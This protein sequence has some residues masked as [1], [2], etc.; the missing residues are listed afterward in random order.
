MPL[1]EII[2]EQALES[3]L[4]GQEIKILFNE[5]KVYFAYLNV[6]HTEM[7]KTFGFDGSLKRTVPGYIKPSIKT[8]ELRKSITFPHEKVKKVMQ[9]FCLLEELKLLDGYNIVY[10]GQ[11]IGVFTANT[12]RK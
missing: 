4:A 9:D 5:R 10:G 11:S 8:I 12:W 3:L 1:I 7:E 2:N 6:Q